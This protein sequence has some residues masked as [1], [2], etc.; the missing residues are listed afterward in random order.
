MAPRVSPLVISPLL[1]FALGACQG[2]PSWEDCQDPS[3]FT[4]LAV[5]RWSTDP[6]GVAAD[7]AALDVVA[8]EAVVLA[9]VD[10][11]PTSLNEICAGLPEGPAAKRCNKLTERPHLLGGKANPDLREVGVPGLVDH[12]GIE[13]LPSPWTEVPPIQADC[14]MQVDSCWNKRMVTAASTADPMK[15]AE[16]CN[17]VPNDRFRREC[18]FRGAETM[19]VQE[20]R[21]RVE[22]LPVATSL[23]LGA[24]DYNE[25]C[26]RELGRAVARLAPPSDQEDPDAWKEAAAAV[27]AMERGLAQYD[28]TVAERVA[29]RV[30]SAVIWG[31]YNRAQAIT[32]APLDSLPPA[33]TPHVRATATWFLLE[34]EATAHPE[35]DL[36][37]WVEIVTTAMAD[38]TA[39]PP[40]EPGG[41][42][43]T[44]FV[45]NSTDPASDERPWAHYLGDNYRA[46]LDDDEQDLVACV[47][48]YAARKDL[49]ALLDQAQAAPWPQPVQAHAAALQAAEIRAP[50]GPGKAR[51][52]AGS[53]PHK[54]R[55][56]PPPGKGQ[57]GPPN[58][59][60]HAP[61]G[62]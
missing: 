47:L 32:G 44:R 39:S 17:A 3:C 9:L 10:A 55:K 11:H 29:D 50:R 21:A 25:L 1:A 59:R 22:R 54:G 36:A 35:R 27:A 4:E 12:T 42:Q 28:A 30:W 58:S 62:R 33:A 57:K 7:I 20:A 18:F 46:V 38:R 31:A 16:V 53:G 19:A 13:A 60:E 61:K 26:V 6:E 14:D 8:Q 43:P 45:G 34:R 41:V 5:Q 40:A 2:E 23:C 52:P 51:G 56:A 49:P 37:A 48:E 15:V 24:E